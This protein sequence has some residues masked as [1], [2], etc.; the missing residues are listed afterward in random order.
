VFLSPP[1]FSLEEAF[2]SAADSE[3]CFEAL[4][5]TVAWRQDA[6]RIAGRQI[7]LPRLTSW[8]G[9]PEAVHTY[10]G[11]RNVPLPWTSEL[12]ELRRKVE[13]ASGASYNS[14]LLNLY[15]GGSDSMGWHAD[16][17]RD[18]LQVIASLSLGAPRT[19]QFRRK[20]PPRDMVSMRLGS[21]SL[22]VMKG[23]TQRH[24]VHRVPKEPAAGERINLTFR[25]VDPARLAPLRRA[26]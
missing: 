22:L 11:I 10:S 18:I 3:R 24:W 15:R 9:E 25:W 1:D 12:D 2:L 16:D 4:K 23:D 13:A 26:S 21:G 8:Y 17:E 14:V 19:F 7:D 6:M 5:R 20:E